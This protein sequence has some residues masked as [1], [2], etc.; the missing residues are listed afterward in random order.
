[1]L[2]RSKI[3][4]DKTK[5]ELIEDIK[6]KIRTVKPF[7]RDPFVRSLKYKNKKELARL[8]RKVRPDSDGYGIHLV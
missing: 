3:K 5:A 1:M 8:N 2:I 4:K 7:I 6:G